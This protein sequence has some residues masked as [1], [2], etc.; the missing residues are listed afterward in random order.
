MR[1][2]KCFRPT[3]RS[4][5]PS[6][7]RAAYLRFYSA[8][9]DETVPRIRIRGY[10]E[11][12]IWQHKEQYPRIKKEDAAIDFNTFK[13]RYRSLGRGDSKPQDEVVVRGMSA[14][15]SAVDLAYTVK[16]EYGHFGLQAQS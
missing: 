7:V 2:L 5:V 13:E 6:T 9:Q 10:E 11:P 4:Y 12:E 15:D 16:E 1:T 8:V 3:L 14:Y